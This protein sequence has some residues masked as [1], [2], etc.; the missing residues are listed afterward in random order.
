[1][2]D[3]D[4]IRTDGRR[5]RKQQRL[6]SSHPVCLVCNCSDIAALTDVTPEWLKERGVIVPPGLMEMHHVVGQKHD[7][8]FVVAL[9]LNCHRKVTEALD[10][11]QITMQ[12]KR[13]SR[14]LV[15]LMLDALAIFL[16]MLVAAVRRWAELLRKSIILEGTHD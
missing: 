10:Q 16:D 8:D 9:C 3:E 4:P 6:G 5:R 1:M 11:G 7:S 14:E 15:A 13:D 12:P 2:I